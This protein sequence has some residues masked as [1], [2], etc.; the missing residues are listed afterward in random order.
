MNRREI[1]VFGLV[2]AWVVLWLGLAFLLWSNLPETKIIRGPAG[3]IQSV[4][5]PF[6]LLR[7]L[8]RLNVIVPFG[9]LLFL[10][11]WRFVDQFTEGDW[12]EALDDQVVRGAV[13]CVLA[14]S[15]FQLLIQG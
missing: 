7:S 13:L 12:F 11:A 3:E 1:F 5:D 14:Y 9:V 6:T 15:I 8:A 10:W 4:Q 2:V